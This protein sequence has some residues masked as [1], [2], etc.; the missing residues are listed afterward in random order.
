MS[1]PGAT[2]LLR[3]T[4][5]GGLAVAWALF[6]HRNS[7]GGTSNFSTALAATPIV[8]V[9]AILLRRLGYPLWIASGGCLAVFGLL[10]LAWPQ[11]RENGALPHFVEH[12]GT[13]LALAVVFGRTLSAGHEPLITQLARFVHPEGLSPTRLRYT[14][15]VTVAW[16]AFFIATAAV[17]TSLFLL[18]PAAVWSVYANFLTLPLIL[19]MFAAEHLCRHLILPPV[20]RDSIA[21]TMRAVRAG[22]LRRASPS[23]RQ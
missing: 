1:A 15:Q 19:L 10:A 3:S 17:S 7:L 2:N 11:L 9:T 16:T 20:E 21:D 13:N 6:A 18:A 5:I 4:A 23:S 12:V 14:R 8:V 22:K